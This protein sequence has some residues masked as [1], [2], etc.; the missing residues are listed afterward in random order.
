M[1]S[2]LLKA[3]IATAIVAA[4]AFTAMPSVIDE[5]DAAT[6][7]SA[8][9][10]IS[11]HI[12]GSDKYAGDNSTMVSFSLKYSYKPYDG[13]SP[14]LKVEYTAKAVDENGKTVDTMSGIETI[15]G[16]VENETV[17]GPSAHARDVFSHDSGTATATATVTGAGELTGT[18][19]MYVG[20]QIYDK[21]DISITVG[22]PGGTGASEST[23][24][25]GIIVAA[26]VCAVIVVAVVAVW[27]IKKN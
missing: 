26:F 17:E 18:V 20:S 14:D 23:I 4:L 25:D 8:T 16:P 27:Y 5:S 10:T 24:T 3:F 22:S 15:S 6:V 11:F 12:T 19:Y 13:S 9:E 2:K 1:A 21:K 7:S